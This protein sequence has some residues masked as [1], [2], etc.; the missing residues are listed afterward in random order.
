MRVIDPVYMKNESLEWINS[1][2]ETNRSFDSCQ[3]MFQRDLVT[4]VKNSVC[5][6]YRIYLS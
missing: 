6:A 1:I 5:F 4:E 3:N 2:S